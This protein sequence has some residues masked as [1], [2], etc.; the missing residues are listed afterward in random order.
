[1]RLV[2]RLQHG[3]GDAGMHGLDQR[4]ADQILEGL[5]VQHQQAAVGGHAHGLVAR[6]ARD[7]RLAAEGIAFLDVG[8]LVLLVVIDAALVH[9]RGAGW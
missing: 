3:L 9:L 2:A 1:M 5:L 8:D 7:Q 6:A 4:G